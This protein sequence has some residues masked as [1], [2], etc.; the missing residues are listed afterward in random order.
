MKIYLSEEEVKHINMALYQHIGRL[1]KDLKENPR[2]G[3]ALDVC[4][5]S[6]A[7]SKKLVSYL[8]DELPND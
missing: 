4:E 3:K 1:E 2:D 8:R 7:T 5:E 6:I